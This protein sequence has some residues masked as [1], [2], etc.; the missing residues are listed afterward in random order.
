MTRPYI[1]SAIDRFWSKVD[2]RGPDD[3]WLWLG[4][5]NLPNDCGMVYGN[6]G[7]RSVSY[8]AHRF[9]WMLAN[10]QIP[11]GL[12]V[13]HKCDVPLCVNPHH[14]FT[15]TA[16]DN[17]RDAMRKGRITKGEN[18]NTAKLTE[19]QV[20][21]IYHSPGGFTE[22]GRAYDVCA[23]TIMKIKRGLSWKHLGLGAAE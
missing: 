17:N 19:D 11:N 9:S 15:G 13:M 2:K 22:L 1:E 7:V 14:L 8:R 21:E 20:V 6:F 12:F 10:G 4:T 16:G 5:K 3:C 18:V 23:T